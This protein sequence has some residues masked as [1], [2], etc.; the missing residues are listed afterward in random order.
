MRYFQSMRI[1][2]YLT[3]LLTADREIVLLCADWEI[4]KEEVLQI[5]A[6]HFLELGIF[7]VFPL[8]HAKLIREKLIYILL[9]STEIHTR[10]EE[11]QRKI[12]Q[13]RERN[14]LRE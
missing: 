9:N 3:R 2:I 14:R 10:R 1:E 5:V 12:A 7:D 8:R 11:I 6:K 13:A 4:E